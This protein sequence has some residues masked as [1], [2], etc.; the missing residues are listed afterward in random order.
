MPPVTQSL[1]I[2]NVV[3]FLAQM[4]GMVPDSFALFPPGAGFEPWQLVTYAFL[5]GGFSHIFL[6]MLALYMF[7]GEIERLFGSRYYL[8]F[9]FA[10]VVTAAITHLV[11]TALMGSPPVPMVGAS[12]GIYG[13]LLAYG[14][15]FPYRRI[16]LLIPP[17]P[18]QARTFVIV[19][20]VVEL[21]LGVM[22]TSAGVAHFAHLGG[23]LG[24][25]LMIQYRRGRFPFGKK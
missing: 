2:A 1:L 10:S 5:H 25:F 16:M 9:Y 11:I 15:Y 24:G 23:M 7:G 18:M 17:I 6:N 19:F 22:Q 3:I 20:A 8:G 12:G 14:M 21:A 4:Q 13:L